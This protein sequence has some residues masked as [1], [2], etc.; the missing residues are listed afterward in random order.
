MRSVLTPVLAAATVALGAV[1]FSP[2]P[3]Q[4]VVETEHILVTNQYGGSGCENH[5]ILVANPFTGALVDDLGSPSS[6][7]GVPNEAKPYDLNRK[8][9]ALWG[10][11]STHGQ[12]AGIGVWDRA[13]RTWQAVPL[14][15]TAF[16]RGANGPH[17]VALLPD[18]YFAIAQTGWLNGSGSGWVV[19]VNGSGTIVDYEQL[20]SAHG[21]EWDTPRNAL[22]AVGYNDVR[23]YTYNTSTHQLTL[24][25]T[26]DIPGDDPGG[27]DLRRR[28]TDSKYW[29]TV[30][31]Q[32][33]VFNPDDGSFTVFTRTDGSSIGGGV[34]SVDQR[35]DGVTEYARYQENDFHFLDRASKS[36]TFC[37]SGYKHGRWLYAPGE[38]VYPEDGETPPPPP[39]PGGTEWSQEAEAFASRPVGGQCTSSTASG[40]LCWN[41]WAN[42]TISTT[43]TAATTGVKRVSVVALGDPS[44]GV[45]PNMRV[46]VDG[47]QV[48]DVTVSST[49]WAA[50]T[51][52]LTLSAGSHTLEVEFTNDTNLNGDDRNLLVDLATLDPATESWRQ[53]VEA[54][55]TKTAGGQTSSSGASGGAYW[56]LWSNGYVETSMS[57][58]ATGG[59]ELHVVARGDVAGGVW[60][61]MKVYVDG[62]L[63]L[64]QTVNTTSWTAYRVRRQLGAGAHTLRVEFTNDAIVGTEDRNLKLDYA[65]LYG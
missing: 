57:A 7:W 44:G 17:S 15:S 32:N 41:V 16:E 59:H 62:T 48:L 10:G 39:P 36:A 23:K 34:K 12:N 29:V 26:Y 38:K 20:N 53:E 54:F 27:H 63:V 1:A 11:S 65:V 14:S 47:T 51:A 42:G 61:V 9:V 33:Y 22:F 45:Y 18:G 37:M 43:M 4:A 55:P 56:N 3:A 31:A 6:S 49:S 24:A 25:G 21:V 28:R 30:N 64:T 52:A 40:G 2:A 13:S 58:G 8:V 46:R 60:P 19:V 50:Y 35:F 5:Q